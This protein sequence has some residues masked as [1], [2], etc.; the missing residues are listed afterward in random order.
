M[1]RTVLPVIYPGFS[2]DV[3][4]ALVSVVCSLSAKGSSAAAK[5]DLLWSHVNKVQA[6]DI[7]IRLLK[8]L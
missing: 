8:A 4:R 2:R 7:R 3:D 1:R 6:G 5:S